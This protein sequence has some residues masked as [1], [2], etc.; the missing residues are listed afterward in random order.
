MDQ[1][2]RAMRNSS[3]LTH[4]T[5]EA[6]AAADLEQL[7]WNELRAYAKELGVSTYRRDRQQLETA[8]RKAMP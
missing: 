8:I 7:D 3:A 6:A 1:R 2:T 5:S 4:P